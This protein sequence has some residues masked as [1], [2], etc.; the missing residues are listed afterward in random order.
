MQTNKQEFSSIKIRI[1]EYLDYKGVTPY[2]FYK[3]SGVT[4]GILTQPNGLSEDNLHKFLAYA[5]DISPMW[6]LSGAGEMIDEKKCT[7]ECTTECT[8][9]AGLPIK[10]VS[11]FSSKREVQTFQ[12][13]EVKRG[14]IPLIPLEAAAGILSG[15]S[16]QIMDYECEYFVIPGF[17]NADFMIQITGDSMLPKYESGDVVA[18]QRLPM[19]TFFQWNCVYVVDSEQ[20]ILIK[21]VKQGSDKEHIELMSENEKYGAFELHLRDINGLGRVVGLVR[22]E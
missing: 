11:S 5:Q 10:N 21:R 9:L 7:T 1:L 12:A 14:G 22:F 2:A 18:C 16:V 3:D 17:K 20:G 4:R 19:T 8:S 6:L 15:S 13:R